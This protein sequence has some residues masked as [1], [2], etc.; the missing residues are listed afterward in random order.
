MIAYILLG[1]HTYKVWCIYLSH[2]GPRAYHQA[3]KSTTVGYRLSSFL[4]LLSLFYMTFAIMATHN[5]GKISA[6]DI[7][8]ELNL[9]PHPEGGFYRRTYRSEL[10]TE[11]GL[12][13]GSAIY[14]L[15]TAERGSA[16]H[17]I[18]G[19]DELWHFYAGD[20]VE[21]RTASPDGILRDTRVLGPG[22]LQGQR[23]QLL[24]PSNHW[25][26]G[27]CLGEWTLFGCSVCPGFDIDSLELAPKGWQPKVE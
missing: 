9:S 5:N 21:V 26:Y 18:H 17:R 16:W 22:V 19:S 12:P 3:V 13:Q 6:D 25:Q 20:P 2:S 7:I 11:A 1:L 23:P 14:Y 24:I 27:R 15:V 8:Q 4:V 10:K